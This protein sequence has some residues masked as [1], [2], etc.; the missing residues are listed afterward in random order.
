M[1]IV[2]PSGR[3]YS[4]DKESPPTESDMASL[5][6]YDASLP[7]PEAPK[8]EPDQSKWIRR[9]SDG[10]LEIFPDVVPAL[11][12]NPEFKAA[13]VRMGGAVS[14]GMMGSRLGPYGVIVGGILGAAGAEPA[15][16]VITPR[17]EGLGETVLNIGMAG[18]QPEIK[19][20]G[21][22]AKML[23]ERGASAVKNAGLGGVLSG[24][25]A[26][27]TSVL[28][29]KRL[30]SPKELVAPVAGGA[31][32]GGALGGAFPA[33]SEPSLVTQ[34]DSVPS[35]A[36]ID[37]VNKAANKI[38]LTPS[39]MKGMTPVSEPR[40]SPT[41]DAGLPLT[42]KE[43]EEIKK[44]IGL[45]KAAS[46]ANVSSEVGD[47]GP[48]PLLSKNAKDSAQA[49]QEALAAKQEVKTAAS[50]QNEVNKALGVN[51]EP[52]LPADQTKL[53]EIIKGENFNAQGK[54]LTPEG[55]NLSDL[56]GQTVQY[57]EAKGVLAQAD[58]GAYVVIPEVRE[59]GTPVR[60]IE[61][62]G[63]PKGKGDSFAADKGV[64][65]VAKPIV[66]EIERNLV[67]TAKD[68]PAALPSLQQDFRR[69]NEIQQKIQQAAKSKDLA[70]IQSPEMKKIWAE[71]E[72]IKNRNEGM[73]PKDPALVKSQEPNVSSAPLAKTEI[74]SPKIAEEVAQGA[75]AD[76]AN[77]GG[78]DDIAIG[79]DQ[80]EVWKPFLTGFKDSENPIARAFGHAA[81]LARMAG[82]V[83][84]NI[85]EI[86]PVVAG[87][88]RRYLSDFMDRS[89]DWSKRAL[90]AF[91]DARKILGKDFDQWS[92]LLLDGK[93]HEAYQLAAKKNG[94]EEMMASLD[95]G[96][97]NVR[98]DIL[99]DHNRT[100][101]G[102]EYEG[103]NQYFPRIVS[104]REGLMKALEISDPGPLKQALEEAMEKKGSA[105]TKEEQAAA[106]SN[107][108]YQ[109]AWNGRGKPGYL[110]E[111]TIEQLGTKLSKYFEPV[112][113]AVE[114]YVTRSAKDITTRE[115]FGKVDP[116]KESPWLN[117][118]DK[119]TGPIGNVL[120]EEIANGRISPEGQKKIVNSINAFF[121]DS[122][123]ASPSAWYWNRLIGS[124]TTAFYLGDISTGIRQATDAF[125]NAVAAGPKAAALGYGKAVQ[126]AA[127]KV[128]GLSSIK[129]ENFTTLEDLGIH[130]GSLETADFARGSTWMARTIGRSI[131]AS[132]GIMDTI[133]KEGLANA[134]RLRSHEVAN[135]PNSKGVTF[136]EAN[137]G[138]LDRRMGEMFPQDWPKMLGEIKSDQFGKEGK[139]TPESRFYL[140]N[141]VSDIQP[142]SR[143]ELPEGM[144]KSGPIGKIPWRLT[145]Y[146][147]RQLGYMRRNVYDE[148]K[149]GNVREAASW[150]AAYS[151]FLTA[152][153][154]AIQYV[155]D[156]AQNKDS[157]PSDY[158]V[159]SLLQ[160][161]G[162]SRYSVSQAGKGDISG[163]IGQR[164][165][166]AGSILK[167]SVSDLQL[168]RDY[169]MGRRHET[170]EKVVRNP[171]DLLKQSEMVKYVPFV[172]RELYGNVGKGSIKEDARKAQ[173]D[174]GRPVPGTLAT[175]EDLIMPGPKKGSRK[176]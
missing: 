124:A 99:A 71:S 138:K 91:K 84:D 98:D 65:P 17:K 136:G 57:G 3:E 172:G 157:S 173:A 167:D 8:E 88:F 151:L 156:K 29:D 48:D 67:S 79:S 165:F 36:S 78:H 28:D 31:L 122:A 160:Q 139:L 126:N 128:K 76:L 62:E 104:D 40:P 116:N 150:F 154:S 6:A 161:V 94:G 81:E 82:T 2:S 14:G 22:L 111:R 134:I 24:L 168:G 129:P 145:S 120:S 108:V 106:I 44:Q 90:P 27:G 159:G 49:I 64:Y 170:G 95:E 50:A 38:A 102:E 163:M 19:A 100:R 176:D 149:K 60:M 37:Q 25:Q 59:A 119:D 155:I 118:N 169:L 63:A 153:N 121:R 101:P 20:G 174:A 52:A 143:G 30:L 54:E 15:A 58:D 77:N 74:P 86:S 83:T 42:L 93:L 68:Q 1:T 51:D 166:P 69:Y 47:S 158:V 56:L 7:E 114:K 130:E 18:I 53:A 46:E 32:V 164:L 73:P 162:A 144:L 171:S 105:L 16:Q 39:E 109:S 35:N 131:R 11:M 107:L 137:F 117:A 21:V 34:I 75:V 112:D 70:F 85:R 55:P 9:G 45:S 89:V 142:V 146:M 123:D 80:H 72:A 133:G 61:I 97:G 12:K 96:W 33:K 110:K 103:L 113:V 152:G 175:V 132:L 41:Q 4:W 127:S 92:T 125:L 141:R 66:P 148:L 115:F 13:A 26:E 147:A 87:R 10:V 135:N 140:F 23:G 5:Q 43:I